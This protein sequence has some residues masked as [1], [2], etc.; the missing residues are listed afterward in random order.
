ME[1]F[2]EVLSAHAIVKYPKGIYKQSKVYRRERK[3]YIKHAGGFVEIRHQEFGGETF[4]TSHPDIKV[5][6]HD[7]PNT[8]LKRIHG[9]KYLR[10]RI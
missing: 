5:L 2:S 8:E 3:L 9:C 10:S 6:D 1:L 7:I 4:A